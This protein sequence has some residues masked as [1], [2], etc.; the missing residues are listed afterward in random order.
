MYELISGKK[1]R[2]ARRHERAAITTAV[3]LPLGGQW[4][5]KSY[6]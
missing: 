6:S 5:G 2:P 3:F 4:H 1:G